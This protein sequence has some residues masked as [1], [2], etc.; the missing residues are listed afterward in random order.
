MIKRLSTQNA[1]FRPRLEQLLAWESVSDTAV[2]KTVEGI[3]ADVRRRGDTALLEYTNRFDRTQARGVKELEIPA[4]RLQEASRRIP[5]ATRA[6][7][8]TAAQRVQ[9]YHEHQK[10]ET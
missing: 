5:A 10:Q 1:D 6:A 2:A 7:L 4:T 8:E 9:S 3:L